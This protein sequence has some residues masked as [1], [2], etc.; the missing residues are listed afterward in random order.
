VAERR[1]LTLVAS[2]ANGQSVSARAVRDK[3]VVRKLLLGDWHP[4]LRDPLD[5]AR[6]SFAIAAVLFL[7]AGKSDA[8][9]ALTLGFAVLVVAQRLNVPRRFDALFIFGVGLSTWGNAAN[10]FDAIDKYDNFVHFIFPMSSVPVLYVLNLRLGVV[11]DISEETDFR[12]RVGLVVFA[13]M[14]GLSLGA[15]YEVYEYVIYNWLDADIEI[16]YADTIWDMT[17][18]TGGALLGGL[19]LWVWA[20]QRWPTER[21]PAV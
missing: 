2:D 11:R 16:G 18:D 19:L 20:S 1:I 14:A 13:A 8:A 10:L 3:R 9:F 21:S 15:L 5:L 4:L 7:L 6:L 17:L 12:H